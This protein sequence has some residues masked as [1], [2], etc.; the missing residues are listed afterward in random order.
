MDF[1]TSLS[2]QRV[3]A[4]SLFQE[5]SQTHVLPILVL[6]FQVKA[7]QKA[8][9]CEA[10]ERAIQCFSLLSLGQLICLPLVGRQP[11]NTCLTQTMVR[12]ITEAEQAGSSD[13]WEDICESAQGDVTGKL[14]SQGRQVSPRPL[15]ASCFPSP[16]LALRERGSQFLH[17][18]S[19]LQPAT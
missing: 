7:L 2:A 9:V 8:T 3:T 1:I 18:C 13:C 17:K 14:T 15:C 11:Q 6:C 19:R 5:V 4:L 10:G 12:K 16:P